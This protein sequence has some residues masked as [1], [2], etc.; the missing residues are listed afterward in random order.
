MNRNNTDK[1]K[2][3]TIMSFIYLV[4][5]FVFEV[6]CTVINV[7]FAME[8]AVYEPP[9]VGHG[10]PF[11]AII[12]FGA[13]TGGVFIGS[14][15]ALKALICRQ[16]SRNALYKH[17]CIREDTANLIASRFYTV[18]KWLNLI[19]MVIALIVGAAGVVALII[20]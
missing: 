2:I 6:L 14:I 7:W 4:Y 18:F 1:F 8:T 20:N 12:F 11:D 13:P 16:A 19:M 10:T 15:T 9:T 5:S 17:S 3:S